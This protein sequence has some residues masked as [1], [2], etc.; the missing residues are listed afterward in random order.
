MDMLQCVSDNCHLLVCHTP[1]LFF[2]PPAIWHHHLIHSPWSQS[3]RRLLSLVPWKRGAGR[4]GSGA[5]Y[6]SMFPLQTKEQFPD[7][8][9]EVRVSDQNEEHLFS[10]CCGKPVSHQQKTF[11]QSHTDSKGHQQARKTWEEQKCAERADGTPTPEVQQRVIS[12]A[13][14]TLLHV[15]RTNELR[16]A[17]QDD[18]GPRRVAYGI[19]IF[20]NFPAI[21]RNWID[22]PPPPRPQ[23]PPPCCRTGVGWGVLWVCGG[24]RP[25]FRAQWTLAFKRCSSQLGTCFIYA[26]H[27]HPH[28]HTPTC[29]HAHTPTLSKAHLGWHS[30]G[31]R[32]A[33]GTRRSR[34][35]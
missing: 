24:R 17:A 19:A 32:M 28:T 35:E 4:G 30:W 25:G 16:Y 31:Q 33:Q 14:P 20:R 9:F 10:M 12:L 11:V 5:K 23:S 26:I 13:Q 1:F 21:F 2:W 27:K 6:C 3:L 29:P 22:P 34:A 8:P 18:L 7:E 15:A